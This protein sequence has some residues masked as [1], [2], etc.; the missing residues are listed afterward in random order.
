MSFKIVQTLEFWI[1][2]PLVTF[3]PYQEILICGGR[4]GGGRGDVGTCSPSKIKL[5]GQWYLRDCSFL[6]FPPEVVNVH[7]KS[8][9]ILADHISNFS[10]INTLV[11][12]YQMFMQII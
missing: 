10:M 2:E 1:Y 9:I 7:N 12:L 8:V 6:I 3:E 5:N 4:G 11:F